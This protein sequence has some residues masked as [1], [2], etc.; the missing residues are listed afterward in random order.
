MI[1]SGVF[2]GTLR[3]RRFSPIAHV[4]T[5]R[6]FMVLLDIDRIPELMR[7]S[8]LLSVNRWNWATFDHRDHVGDPALPLR[9]RLRA[10]AERHGIALPAG[11]AMLLT[12]L[13]YLGYGF[14]PIS[15]FYLF[16]PAG[17]LEVVLAD[18]HNTFGQ[19]H[20]YWLRRVG[21]STTFRASAPKA[22]RVSPFM[23]MEMD[24]HF[25]LTVPDAGLTAHIE[26][27]HGEERVLDATLSLQRR[28]WTASEIRRQ[29]CRFPAMTGTVIA[30]IHWQALRLWW[31]GLRAVPVKGAR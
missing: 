21:S 2:V 20:R 9:E 23:P 12:N 10:D 15:L 14:N 4:F 18:V 3:H 28:P 8:R 29:L 16:D 19:S 17:A 6:V 25:S 26:T 22:L 30:G 27:W 1:D 11:R 31:K 13:R 7:V 5:Y 24:Y